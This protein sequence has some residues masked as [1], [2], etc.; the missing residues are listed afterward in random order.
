[1][2]A[3]LFVFSQVA[4]N[5]QWGDVKSQG[6]WRLYGAELRKTSA[7]N[8]PHAYALLLNGA[9]RFDLPY[10]SD[11][12]RLSGWGDSVVSGCIRMD[13]IGPAYLSFA[14]QRGGYMEPP[15]NDDTLI[16]WGLNANGQWLPLWR[17]EGTGIAETTFSVVH[18]FIEDAQWLHPC[19]TLKWTVWGSTYGAYDNW[20]VGYTIIRRDTQSILPVWVQLPRIYD[21]VYAVWPYTYSVFDSVSARVAGDGMTPFRTEVFMNGQYILRTAR[22]F[23]PGGDTIRV[24]IPVINSPGRFPVRWALYGGMVSI[25]SFVV[26]DT[27]II[28]EDVWGFDDGEMESGYGLLQANRPFCQSFRIDTPHRLKSIGVKFF[29][30]PAQYGK[31]FQLGV[32]DPS[33]NASGPLYLKFQRIISDTTSDWQWFDLDTSIVVR[34]EICVGLVQLEAQPLGVGWDMNCGTTSVKVQSSGGWIPSELR[35]CMMIRVKL[36]PAVASLPSVSERHIHST[37]VGRAG[38]EI[39]IPSEAR[40]PLRVWNMVG[41]E[42]FLNQASMTIPTPGVYVCVDAA[43][44][45]WRLIIVP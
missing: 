33:G 18:L 10:Q 20:F 8:A 13:S 28:G 17:T 43:G 45:V 12:P 1:M 14:Y 27:L 2:I 30:L 3:L 36:E 40:L 21:A 23:S 4:L 25:D 31:P 35:G 37:I 34:G 7:Y 41:A 38:Q 42:S 15:E 29:P 9:S 22:I 44:Q 16:L 32:W 11:N 26:T 19:F 24:R 39:A 5:R 6:F